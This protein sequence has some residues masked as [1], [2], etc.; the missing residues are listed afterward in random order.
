MARAGL[1]ASARVVARGWLAPVV[2]EMEAQAAA[3][4]ETQAAAAPRSTAPYR[5]LQPGWGKGSSHG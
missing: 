1:V 2:T 4:V 5:L 3:E